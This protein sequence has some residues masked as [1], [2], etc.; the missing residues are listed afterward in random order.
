VYGHAAQD[1]HLGRAYVYTLRH[2]FNLVGKT[3]PHAQAHAEPRAR[4]HTRATKPFSR[5]ESAEV[6]VAA[7]EGRWEATVP[8]LATIADLRGIENRLVKWVL[9][10]AFGLLFAVLGIFFS[11]YTSI[12]ARFD[13]I[14]ARFDSV[15]TRL[16]STNSRID[17]AVTELRAE[18]RETNARMDAKFDALM[19]EL[20]SQRSDSR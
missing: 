20:R 13:S 18:I 8:T 7:L 2:V 12:N 11:G 1:L 6:R 5:T 16:D 4:E 9:G 15:N 17:S 14:T 10:A 3:S 19:A